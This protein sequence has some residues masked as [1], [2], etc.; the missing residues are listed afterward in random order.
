MVTTRH[1]RRAADHLREYGKPARLY[2]RIMCGNLSTVGGKCDRIP[3]VKPLGVFSA[4]ARPSW[5]AFAGLPDWADF[6]QAADD[7]R[8]TGVWWVLLLYSPDRATP[9]ESVLPGIAE[10]LR[11]SGLLPYVV[12]VC[13]HEEWYSGWRRGDFAIP[14]LSPANYD[15]WMAAATAIHGWV[16]QQHRALR[17]ALGLPIVWLDTFVNDDPSFGAAYYQPV[18][19]AV[20][21]LAIEAY[22]PANGLWAA[23]VEPFLQHAVSTR[24]EPIVLVIQG[25]RVRGD[26]LWDRGPTHDSIEGTRRWLAHDRVIS[27]WVFD[28]GSRAG[29]DGLADLPN[30]R[31]VEAAL[32]VR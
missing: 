16:S 1:T 5:A 32:G 7:S 25:F 8:R 6:T 3:R 13:Y 14:G 17:F 19:D 20:D 23:D 2:A 28:W 21:C 30:R 15:H 22:V 11:T 10:R 12:G 29:M 26:S 27:G 9:L 31:E 24:R 4:D 18:P